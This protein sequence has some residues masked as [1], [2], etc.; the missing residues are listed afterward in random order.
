MQ[1]L[2]RIVGIED[3]NSSASTD[4]T[5]EVCQKIPEQTIPLTEEIVPTLYKEDWLK[6]EVC[7]SICECFPHIKSLN[8]SIT[9]SKSYIG[10]GKYVDRYYLTVLWEN[11]VSECA[12]NSIVD[13]T[14]NDFIESSE[15]KVNPSTIKVQLRRIFTEDVILR[16][17]RKYADCIAPH[18]PLNSHNIHCFK[19]GGVPIYELAIGELRLMD[20]VKV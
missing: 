18:L 19:V 4:G 2:K 16:E 5:Q 8:I 17:C 14:L 13:C 10:N 3:K 7:S 11:G 9:P 1:Y 20:E 6:N 12:I 15:G